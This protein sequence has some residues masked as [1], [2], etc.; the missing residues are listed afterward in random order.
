MC[1]LTLIT[2]VQT[3]QDGHSNR[4]FN[5]PDKLESNCEKNKETGS[6]RIERQMPGNYSVIR[7]FAMH[8]IL[9]LY[10]FA[11]DLAIVSI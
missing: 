1:Y 2:A 7:M 5:P 9:L 10:I 3:L 11:I 6:K 8:I 4:V